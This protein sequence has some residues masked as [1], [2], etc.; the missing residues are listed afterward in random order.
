MWKLT[1]D[2]LCRDHWS[3]P[4]DQQCWLPVCQL[5]LW[6]LL[7]PRINSVDH[8]YDDCL[9]DN[10]QYPQDQQC[11][12]PLWWSPLWWSP[13]WWSSIPPGSTVLITSTTIV[14]PPTERMWLQNVIQAMT[15][16]YQV[17]KQAH[18]PSMVS[19]F[20]AVLTIHMPLLCWSLKGREWYVIRERLES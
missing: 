20:P 13:L 11:W 14:D 10:H 5:P 8:L 3:V 16:W 1:V 2:P 18:R 9:Y 19:Q 12:P 15:H 6:W 17:F 4:Q 7:I